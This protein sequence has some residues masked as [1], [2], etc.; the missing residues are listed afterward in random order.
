MSNNSNNPHR[1]KQNTQAYWVVT[2]DIACDLP[3]ETLVEADSMEQA[4]DE[5]IKEHDQDN[6]YGPQDDGGFIPCVAYTREDLLR[7][8]KEMDECQ[9]EA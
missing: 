8:L 6:G 7:I 2:W 4:D 5:A 1:N 9:S 3:R